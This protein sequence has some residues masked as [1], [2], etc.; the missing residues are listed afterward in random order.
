MRSS[1]YWSGVA[2]WVSMVVGFV[3]WIEVGHNAQ[4][5]VKWP[6]AVSGLVEGLAVLATVVVGGI[7]VAWIVA[8]DVS[9]GDPRR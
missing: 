9:A 2:F 6:Y 4:Q 3:A 1:R 8:L 5:P 7:V